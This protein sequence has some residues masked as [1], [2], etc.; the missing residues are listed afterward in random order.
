MSFLTPLTDAMTDLEPSQRPTVDEALVQFGDIVRQQPGYR[1]RWNLK[2]VD[3]TRTIHLFD[4]VS[5]IGRE[6]VYQL[7][8]IISEA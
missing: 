6:C 3:E 8:R 1:L 2:D 5:S 7:L 4:D